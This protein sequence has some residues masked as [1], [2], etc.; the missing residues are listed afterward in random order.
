MTRLSDSVSTAKS[1]EIEA[2]AEVELDI[3]DLASVLVRGGRREAQEKVRTLEERW[4]LEVAPHLA[5]AGVTDLAGLDAKVVEAQELDARIK[6]KDTEI[7]SLRSQI[8]PLDRRSKMLSERHWTVWRIAEAALG[9]VAIE[10]L[11]ADLDKLGSRYRWR[12]AKA[13]STVVQGARYGSQSVR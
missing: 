4:N 13:A 6:A 10:T 5:A 9:D 2:N 1:F 12:F 8:E 3:A 11:S 7:E